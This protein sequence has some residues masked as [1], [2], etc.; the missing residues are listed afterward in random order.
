MAMCSIER[1]AAWCGYEAPT[2]LY[3]IGNS[4]TTVN[5]FSTT[6]KSKL[7]ILRKFT[8]PLHWEEIPKIYRSDR[9]KFT[10][11]SRYNPYVS[12]YTV[13]PDEFPLEITYRFKPF[14]PNDQQKFKNTLLGKGSWRETDLI[15]ALLED[16]GLRKK[17]K[18]QITAYIRKR[19]FIRNRPLN[20]LKVT[21]NGQ[22]FVL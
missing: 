13:S 1:S 4:R 9:W 16:G 6:A 22:D 10:P 17:I 2:P 19:T 11:H 18:K 12:P 8:Y 5:D 20:F 21:V 14:T 3:V 7:P 15:I